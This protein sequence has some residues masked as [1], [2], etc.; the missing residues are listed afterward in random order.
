MVDGTPQ[1]EPMNILW[2]FLGFIGGYCVAIVQRYFQRRKR[3]RLMQSFYHRVIEH[4]PEV[5]NAFHAW[6]DEKR[7]LKVRP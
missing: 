7:K 2:Y 3:L 5:M 6:E 1:H 4:N